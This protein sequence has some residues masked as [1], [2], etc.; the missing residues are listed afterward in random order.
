M[1]TELLKSLLFF[2]LAI[3]IA[4]PLN[5][6]ELSQVLDNSLKH[7]NL[8]SAL[9]GVKIIDS[10]SNTVIFSRNADKSFVPAS[11]TKLLTGIAGLL[12]L[13]KDFRFETKLY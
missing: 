2:I 4:Y 10:Q 5:S 6:I 9:V 12:F 1:S 13:G 7:N 8:Q 3:S 11:N